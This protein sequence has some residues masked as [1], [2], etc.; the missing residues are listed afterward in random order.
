MSALYDTDAPKKA[1]NITINTDLLRQAKEYNINLS[2]NFEAHLCE[3]VREKK[4]Q[5]WLED[6]AEAIEAYNSRVES[7]GMFSD[8]YRCF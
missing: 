6:N 1:T 5:Q 4:E 2:K 7:S 8:A 3:I